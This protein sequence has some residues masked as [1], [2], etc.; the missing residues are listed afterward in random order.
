MRFIFMNIKNLLSLAALSF[1]FALP[2]VAMETV[3]S[4][5][6]NACNHVAEASKDASCAA[7]EAVK[8]TP[9]YAKRIFASIKAF[10]SAKFYDA[11]VFVNGVPS[12]SSKKKVVVGAAVAAGVAVTGYALYKW[13]NAPKKVVLKK[14][15]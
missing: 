14:R 10:A 4:K 8:S 7:K 12:W 13:Y 15:K 2:S 9:D 5:C 1:F 11:K 3:T 6:K